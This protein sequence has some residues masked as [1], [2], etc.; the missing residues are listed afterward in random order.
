MQIR[1][2][3]T[4]GLDMVA[5]KKLFILLPLFWAFVC[6]YMIIELEVLNPTKMGPTT[7]YTLPETNKRQ[8]ENTATVVTVWYPMN[9]KYSP[10]QYIR[11]MQ[12]M[13]ELDDP[14]VVFTT[15]Q[16]IRRIQSFREKRDTQILII[17]SLYYRIKLES[18][19][20]SQN[21]ISNPTR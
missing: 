7:N 3:V 19:L 20:K 8:S 18:E 11:W 1:L 17:K 6:V 2:R 21:Q 13:L 14:M 9:S 12:N 4:E 15:S 10:I 16:E 5:Y